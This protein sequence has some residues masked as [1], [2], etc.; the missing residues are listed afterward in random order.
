MA[1]IVLLDAGVIGLLV[2][3]P[4]LPAVAH[5]IAWLG[6]LAGRADVTIPD[7]AAFEVRRELLRIGASRKLSNLASLRARL[8]RAE[9]TEDAWIK[10]AEFWA[11]VRRAG[12]PTANPE[13]L[14][15]D[16]ILAGVAAT[17]GMPGDDVVIATT[18]VRHLTRFPG[19]DA[20]E[21]RAVR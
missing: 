4:H 18:N 21:W 11:L 8:L 5:G 16:A 12:K 15:A 19:I 17:L 10:A 7:V 2:S 1:R 9:V 14:D 6:D 13:A 3:D 20:R